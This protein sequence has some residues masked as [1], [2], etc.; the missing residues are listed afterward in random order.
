[1]QF[2]VDFELQKFK[3]KKLQTIITFERELGLRRSKNESCSKWHISKGDSNFKICPKFH[4]LLI[5]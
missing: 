1:M 2:I 5:F 3:A 4:R